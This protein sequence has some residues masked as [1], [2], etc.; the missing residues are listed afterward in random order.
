[1]FMSSMNC[2]S[3]TLSLFLSFSEATRILKDIVNV[4]H[5]YE[6][7]SILVKGMSAVRGDFSLTNTDT[8]TG[9]SAD[10]KKHGN[11]VRLKRTVEMYQWV[12]KEH[13]EKQK[14]HS[15]KITYTYSLEWSKSYHDSSHFHQVNSPYSGNSSSSN[16]QYS[17]RT[18][19]THVNPVKSPNLDC[20]TKNAST[21]VGGYKL[22]EKQMNMLCDYKNVDL[23]SCPLKD[24][25]Q[26][27]QKQVS[28]Q[29]S[30]IDDISY[31]VYAANGDSSN[32]IDYPQVGLVRISYDAIY[33]NGK[34]TALGVL[35]GE[36]FRAFTEKDAHATLGKG[37]I[38][39]F[40]CSFKNGEGSKNGKGKKRYG[41]NDIESPLA[42]G[43]GGDDDYGT[44]DENDNGDNNSSS[45]NVCDACGWLCPCCKI[46]SFL[47]PM[48]TSC[49]N[50]VVGDEV[51]LVEE[52]HS[53]MH[54]MFQ[55]LND[56]FHFRLRISRL[57]CVILFWIAVSLI[58]SPISTLL[59]F[60][61]IVGGLASGL[62]G[63]LTFILAMILAFLI[64]SIA[65]TIFHPEYMSVLLLA[66]GLPCWFSTTVAAGWVTFG[67]VCT[68][69]SVIP[70]TMFALNCIEECK[71]ASEQDKLDE[72]LAYRS[73]HMTDNTN[74]L[75]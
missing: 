9:F 22:C 61:P 10:A 58:F 48:M 17:D 73:T 45:T 24:F 52:R 70:A 39:A 75:V 41:A 62:F 13:R 63:L 54:A 4:N 42:P 32:T 2:S 74:L 43:S 6:N 8:D 20:K 64:T 23:A 37:G 36:T 11:L 53:S 68:C 25:K 3:L 72:D 55:H 15:D 27:D 18:H 60:L 56:A 47:T 66:V 31:L 1:M 7:R 21:Y 16:V 38:R 12:E 57:I 5:N 30:Q 19:V 51:I 26:F 59:G 44:D 67:I 33:E 34:I 46:I 35:T 14:G 49:I 29:K 65:W 50:N 71:Y 69:M 28:I 40:C